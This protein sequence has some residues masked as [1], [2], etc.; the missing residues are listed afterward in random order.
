MPLIDRKLQKAKVTLLV[1][2]CRVEILGDKC[3]IL[4][5]GEEFL[6]EE[7]VKEHTHLTY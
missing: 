7:G 6:L 3:Y 5:D 4:S 1:V 2:P